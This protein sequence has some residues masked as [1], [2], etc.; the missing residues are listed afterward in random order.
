MITTTENKQAQEP[1]EE[2]LKKDDAPLG[3]GA[4]W[5]GKDLE[6]RAMATLKS[7]LGGHVRVSTLIFTIIKY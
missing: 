7:N 4:R 5:Q 2:L 3:S 1:S 6:L